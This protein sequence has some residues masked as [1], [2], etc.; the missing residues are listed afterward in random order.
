MKLMGGVSVGKRGLILII[1]Q[2]VT[3]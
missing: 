3:S 1:K 2:W